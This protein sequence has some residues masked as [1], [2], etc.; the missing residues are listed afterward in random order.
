MKGRQ[1]EKFVPVNLCAQTCGVSLENRGGS[2]RTNTGKQKINF[3]AVSQ[4]LTLLCM[5]GVSHYAD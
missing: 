3:R 4:D 2:W 1:I 5:G